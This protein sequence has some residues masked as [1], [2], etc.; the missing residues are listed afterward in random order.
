MAIGLLVGMSISVT[1]AAQQGGEPTDRIV[2]T[3]HHVT[4][5]GKTLNYTARAGLLP[6]RNNEAGDVHGHMFFIAYTM[7]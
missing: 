5:A 2:T 4:A 7:E 1:A 3:Q 6:I